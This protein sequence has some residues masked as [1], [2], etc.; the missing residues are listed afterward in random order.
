MK[1]PL[2][3][4]SAPIR[5]VVGAVVLLAGCATS[6]PHATSADDMAPTSGSN[7]VSA[8]AVTEHRGQDDLLTA[9][10]GLDGLRAMTPPGFAD[11]AAPTPAELRRRA[12][13]SNWRGIA[14]LAPGGGYGEL[15]GNVAAVP[16][17]EFQALAQVPGASQPHRVLVQVPDNFDQQARCI[18][19]A[20]ASGSRGVLGAIAVAGPWALPKGCAVAYT[21]KGNGNDYFDLDAGLGVRLDGTIGAPSADQPLAFVP[22][23]GTGSGIAVKHAHSRDNP[24][25]DWGRHV[26]QAAEFAL[27]SLDQAFPDAAPFAFDNTTVIAVGV[28]N[29]GGA[30]LRAAELEGDWL[31]AVVAGEPNVQV[32]GAR[33]LYD[34]MTE[35]A[36][37]M[38]CALPAL[39]IPPMPTAAAHCAA[40]AEAG[41]VSGSTLEQQQ[42]SAYDTLRANG[43]TDAAMRAGSISVAFDLW[44][45]VAVTYAS[46]YGRHG[47][48]EHP[49]GYSFAAQE[50]DGTPRPATAAE[51]AAWTAD[52]GGIPPGAGVGIIAPTTDATAPLAQLQ[53]LRAL[54]IGEGA[55]ADRVRAGIE[56]IRAGLPREGLPIMVVHGLDDGLIPPAFSSTP[57][58]AAA[59]AAER[60]V[61]YWQ[62]RNAQHFDA[63]LG[64]PVYGA[65]YLPLLPY[66]YEALDRTWEHLHDGTPLPADAVIETTPRGK[67]DAP[68]EAADLAIPR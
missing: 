63:F 42:K 30:V 45:A 67:S 51:R 60:D 9:G 41:L 17:R 40:L 44:R 26:K 64:L 13:W 39:G 14:D 3:N 36:L 22:E 31:D 68:L 65:Q 49:C 8:I 4:L 48:D 32:A 38:P 50:K 25:A 55:N 29:G 54:W 24:E 43:W 27:Q 5:P 66:V 19:V 10:L 23:P 6:V 34:Y 33:P 57:Y 61:R 7:L 1:M 21:D 16:G 56:E 62:V 15:Y 52:G 20:P 53:C 59:Q 37:L 12:V 2:L 47:V 28:S 46:A 58:V 35:A 18:V 11:P